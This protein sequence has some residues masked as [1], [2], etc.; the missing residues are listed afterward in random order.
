MLQLAVIKA[1]NFTEEE[2]VSC[3]A[4]AEKFEPKNTFL[5]FFIVVGDE[6]DVGAE[7][8]KS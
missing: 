6:G 2:K 4:E 7:P 1:V 3:L 5:F 8:V